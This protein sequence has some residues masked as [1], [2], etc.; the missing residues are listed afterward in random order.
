MVETIIWNF[1]EVDRRHA[2][3]EPE[4]F[5]N[6]AAD[7]AG[8]KWLAIWHL[9]SA[10]EHILK[11]VGK[12]DRRALAAWLRPLV[13]REHVLARRAIGV[14]GRW[15]FSDVGAL[16]RERDRALRVRSAELHG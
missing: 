16:W 10:V 4:R 8:G 13:A 9:Q 6:R 7:E 12:R 2:R 1:D 5:F 15:R 3:P 11:A 14:N